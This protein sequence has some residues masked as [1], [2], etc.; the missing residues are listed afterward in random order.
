MAE[1]MLDIK[2]IIEDT[3]RR[4]K[5]NTEKKVTIKVFLMHNPMTMESMMGQDSLEA[6]IES[7][8]KQNLPGDSAINIQNTGHIK[9]W[10]A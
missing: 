10:L 4:K 1:I 6:I 3:G 8:M 9:R 2:N 5:I 7:Q